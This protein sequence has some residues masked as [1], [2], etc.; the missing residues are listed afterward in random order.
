MYQTIRTLY[1]RSIDEIKY[2]KVTWHVRGKCWTS[3]VMC[4]GCLKTGT[5]ISQS[6]AR[7]M[8]FNARLSGS[9]KDIH[10]SYL[11]Y[12]YDL[13]NTSNK[14]VFCQ[15]T[16]VWLSAD[17]LLSYGFFDPRSIIRYYDS[18]P[19]Q[20]HNCSPLTT[21]GLVLAIKY[22]QSWE[23]SPSLLASRHDVRSC[24]RKVFISTHVHVKSP[25]YFSRIRKMVR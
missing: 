2:D 13:S 21:H 7:T 6:I 15:A 5:R 23:E 3:H 8:G 18:Y 14:V 11:T 22:W 19:G 25:R 20:R 10:Y 12:L 4:P 9:S 16:R 24:G 17:A 1:I